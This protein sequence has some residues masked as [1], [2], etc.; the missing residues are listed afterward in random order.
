MDHPLKNKSVTHKNVQP[1]QNGP[2]GPN[3]PKPVDRV[4]ERVP[5][6]VHT[7]HSKQLQHVDQDNQRRQNHVIKNHAYQTL[8]GPIGPNG[9][10]VAK[11][12][13]EVPKLST[14]PVEYQEKPS[15]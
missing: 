14:E 4:P 7:V 10:N 9:Q 1:G 13:V 15:N 6:C 3:A 2:H 8:N 12:V 11:P 5:E